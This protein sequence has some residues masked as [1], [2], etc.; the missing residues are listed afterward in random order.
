M[1]ELLV[2]S[3]QQLPSTSVLTFDLGSSATNE[4]TAVCDMS[5]KA[6]R[7]KEAREQRAK[8]I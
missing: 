8:E 4:I 2:N 1:N 3:T 5:I 6:K 7:N